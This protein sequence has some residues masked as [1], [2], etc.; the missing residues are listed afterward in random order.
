MEIWKVIE[1]HPKYEVSSYG[2]VRNIKNQRILKGSKTVKG[3]YIRVTLG[4]KQQERV[5]RLVAIAHIINHNNYPDV[6]HKD[7][8]P[9]NNHI[10]NLQWILNPDNNKSH[11]K[12]KTRPSIPFTRAQVFYM[13]ENKGVRSATSLANE[14]GCLPDAVSKVWRGQGVRNRKWRQE[15]LSGNPSNIHLFSRNN[16]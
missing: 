7:N 12:N 13:L 15:Y 10:D 11:N 9:S 6:H 1:S 14:I 3:G 8:D 2:Y 4:I 5:H 16:E